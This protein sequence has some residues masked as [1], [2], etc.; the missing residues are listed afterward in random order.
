MIFEALRANALKTFRSAMK[1]EIIL[2]I[3]AQFL[4]PAAVACSQPR[5]FIA[6]STVVVIRTP[7]EIYVGA[8]SK[9]VVYG[10][11]TKRS[12]CKIRQVENLFFAD[13]GLIG[14]SAGRFNVMET[15]TRAYR[16]SDS[17]S[18]TVQAFE[19]MIVGPFITSLE[20]VKRDQPRYYLRYLQGR[21]N[22]SI[23]FFGLEKDTLVVYTRA[24]NATESANG[25]IKVDVQR[26]DCPDGCSTG[27]TYFFLGEY[28]AI[29]TFLDANP[30][31]SKN[32]LIPAI[33][34]L[35][36]IEIA[37]KPDFVGYPIDIMRVDKKGAAWIQRKVECPD[38]KLGN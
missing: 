24:F 23:V 4:I 1:I 2:A 28:E 3:V 12:T 29:D 30:H 13:T 14:D 10:D 31:Y 16:V 25:T 27:I 33:L 26:Q 35:I 18:S 8:D 21:A 19:Q 38:V 15:V 22:F 20:E 34:K 17:I 11:D 36:E 7:S 5:N 9:Q 32:G 6:G 37:D